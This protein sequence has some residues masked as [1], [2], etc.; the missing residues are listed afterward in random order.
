ML[1]FNTTRN[2]FRLLFLV[3]ALS[4]QAQADSGQSRGLL[5]KIEG[6]SSR[7]S[8]LLGTMHSE[9]PRV[10]KLAPAVKTIFD[11][12]DS[13]SAELDMN[14]ENLLQSSQRMFYTD[15][16]T[17]KSLID[18][19]LYQDSVTLLAKYGIPE[20]LVERMKP[21]AVATTLSMPKT[22]TGQFLDLVLFRQAQATG[23]KVYG[24][25]TIDE[26]LAVFENMPLKQ[27]INM[28]RD[29]VRDYDAGQVM[30]AELLELYIQRDLEGVREL[31]ERYMDKGD[32]SVAAYFQKTIID[33]R[34]LRMLQRMQARLKEGNAFI[35]V[36]A[37]HLTGEKG[38]L[39][40]LEKQGLKVSPVY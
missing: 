32:D 16:T 11:R 13:F 25:E 24:L 18:A 4:L 30:L 9:D 21:W 22:E 34:N 23:K 20:M 1:I 26:Q 29:A 15:D 31:S 40:L 17:L 38:L 3:L 36:G 8:Y 2:L 12:A 14:M 27:Q 33:D 5:W 6:A 39:H 19:R 35:A 28:L 7:P 10:V 37:L